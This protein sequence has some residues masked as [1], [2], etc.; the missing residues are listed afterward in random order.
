[1]PGPIQPPWVRLPGRGRGAS[2]LAGAVSGGLRGCESKSNWQLVALIRGF[3]TET[4]ISNDDAYEIDGVTLWVASPHSDPDVAT[5]MTTPNGITFEVN[6]AEYKTIGI[7]VKDVFP[8]YK[9]GMKLRAFVQFEDTNLVGG[10][11]TGDG[12]FMGIGYGNPNN[13]Y[14]V[15][16]LAVNAENDPGYRIAAEEDDGIN[17]ANQYVNDEPVT[18]LGIQGAYPG[19]QGFQSS[20]TAEPTWADLAVFDSNFWTSE[21]NRPND[22]SDEFG[23]AD[24]V[25][26]YLHA[27]TSDGLY[28]LIKS[29]SIYVLRES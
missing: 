25:F 27:G 29:I 26:V 6:T 24:K 11:S 15:S 13:L 16:A 17:Y 20:T 18:V 2:G 9:L 3:A 4:D 22:T 7:R 28:G 12:A 5:L 1:M 23:D 19:W 21:D 8:D 14:Y 10:E